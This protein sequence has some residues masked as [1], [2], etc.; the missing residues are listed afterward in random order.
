MN[1]IRRL[2]FPV[3]SMPPWRFYLLLLVIALQLL[4]AYCLAEQNN[5]FFYQAF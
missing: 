1:L 5:P 4:L 3:Q 2:L